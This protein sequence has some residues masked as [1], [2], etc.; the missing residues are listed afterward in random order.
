[1]STRISSV[2]RP[3]IGV[4]VIATCRQIGLDRVLISERLSDRS[5]GKGYSQ[6]PGGHLEFG[7]TFEQ[8]AER[9]LKE[10]TNLQCRSFELVYLTN[11]IFSAEEGGPKHYLTLFLRGEILDPSELKW[12]EKEKN[13]EWI[14]TPWNEL[15]QK[16]L[17]GPLHQAVHDEQF[18][19][20]E[21]LV[22]HF[23]LPFPTP[24]STLTT[25]DK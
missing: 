10:E 11:T 4:A 21:R 17:F 22:Q 12:M 7:E 20:F 9:E 2:I 23:Y 13:S 5:H 16:K 3:L 24:T 14:W 15:K 8:C 18:H 19:P 6:L 1:M 25:T